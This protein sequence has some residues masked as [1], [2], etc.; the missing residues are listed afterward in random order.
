MLLIDVTNMDPL[1]NIV[2]KLIENKANSKLYSISFLLCIYNYYIEFV[3][4]KI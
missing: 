1:D 3:V 2:N 4:K